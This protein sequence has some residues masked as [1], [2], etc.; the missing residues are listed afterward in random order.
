MCCSIQLIV[1]N[2]FSFQG[3]VGVDTQTRHFHKP[4]HQ[5]KSMYVREQCCTIILQTTS[6]GSCDLTSIQ[7]CANEQRKR[8]IKVTVHISE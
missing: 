7:V 1:L 6:E 5:V 8:K 3:A 4:S 2:D